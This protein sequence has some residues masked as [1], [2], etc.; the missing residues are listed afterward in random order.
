[1]SPARAWA[2]VGALPRAHDIH[3]G[4]VEV[5]PVALGTT[6]LYGSTRRVLSQ[7]VCGKQAANALP[8]RCSIASRAPRTTRG[9]HSQRSAPSGSGWSAMLSTWIR[10]RRRYRRSSGPGYTLLVAEGTR[11][12]S[13]SGRRLPRGV[14]RGGR[15]A[16]A[17]GGSSLRRRCHLPSKTW[18]N[19]LMLRRALR[20]VR[21]IYTSRLIVDDFR[22]WLSGSGV[23][24]FRSQ[25]LVAR[26]ASVAHKASR[27]CA[28][29][30]RRQKNCA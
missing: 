1:M 11:C 27:C 6:A 17:G 12:F 9:Y 25:Y 13:R 28:Y 21:W 5:A 30:D 3:V 15:R 7:R 4:L 26:M 16:H 22:P 20:S 24:G 23:C 8:V 10:C 29:S 2:R 18:P 14:G 19:P